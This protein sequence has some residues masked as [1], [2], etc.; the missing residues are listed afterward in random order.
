MNN[1]NYK[2]LTPFKWYV[3]ENFPFI[4]ADFDALTEWQLFCKLGWEINKVI[5]ST[6]GLG[7]EVQEL[8]NYLNTLDFQD[9]V[10]NKLNEMVEDGTLANIINQDIFSELNSKVDDIEK[11]IN[12]N[13]DAFN[14]TLE[15]MFTIHTD[16][17]VFQGL[18]ADDN[19]YYYANSANAIPTTIYKRSLASNELINT[20]VVNFHHCNDLAILNNILYSATFQDE[21]NNY[22]RKIGVYN[23]TT[24]QE[25]TIAPFETQEIVQA[26]Y[27]T[28]MQISVY[29]ENHLLCGLCK[30]YNNISGLGLFLLDLR[31]NSYVEMPLYN[32]KNINDNYFTSLQ[33]FEYLNNRLYITTTH[34]SGIIEC[35]ENNNSFYINNI[36]HYSSFDI[37]GQSIGELEG[38]TKTPASFNG[39]GTLLL[40]TQVLDYNRP[41]MKLK[42]Y[43]INNETNLPLTYY[44]RQQQVN[45]PGA[46][47]EIFVDESAT[48]YYE[49]GSTT[50]PFHDIY[51]AIELMN[52]SNYIKGYRV[53]VKAGIYN[54]GIL[55]SVNCVFSC[56]NNTIFIGVINLDNSNIYFS[57]CSFT[58]TYFEVTNSKLT[59]TNCILEYSGTKTLNIQLNSNV[60][61]QNCTAENMTSY[62]NITSSQVTMNFTSIS[63]IGSQQLVSANQGTILFIANKNTIL[64]T[65]INRNTNASV[66]YGGYINQPT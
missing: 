31:N 12:N 42:F 46:M 57:N 28:L 53:R 61:F 52:N 51:S 40:M 44:S 5:K 16:K 27:V 2:K 7:N 19:Y 34:P 66:I 32:N 38:I 8:Y 9:E 21:N 48:N 29:D 14:P 18:T 39:K 25:S 1:F 6:N 64:P 65:N 10:N 4:E 54:I 3:L 36:M 30:S 55:H 62:F 63:R 59:F 45:T 35:Y 37:L 47:T 22:S 50:Y 17:N 26:G 56:E 49:D 13:I 58:S 24:G 15:Y 23:I 43:C 33:S 41:A 20:Y 60:L 11:K